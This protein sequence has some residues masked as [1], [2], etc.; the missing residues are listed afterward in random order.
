MTSQQIYR[1]GVL[2]TACEGMK[3]H[4]AACLLAGT[5]APA[6]ATAGVGLL[7]EFGGNN[8][9][10][11]RLVSG[12]NPTPHWGSHICFLHHEDSR[13]TVPCPRKD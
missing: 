10:A 3:H 5:A 4:H 8:I 2:Q 12:L 11:V 6:D 7:A 13:D 1:S 9:L